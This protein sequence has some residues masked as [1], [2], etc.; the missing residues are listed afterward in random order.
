MSITWNQVDS[1]LIEHITF[2]LN[3]LILKLHSTD[4]LLPLY[5][6]FVIHKKTKDM[7]SRNYTF[8]Q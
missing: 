4:E 7:S 6:G 5:Q 3:I 2:S 8:F 1:Q